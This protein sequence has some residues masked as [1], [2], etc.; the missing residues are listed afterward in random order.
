MSNT[1]LITYTYGHPAPVGGRLSVITLATELGKGFAG[2]A[3]SLPTRVTSI[4]R[5]GITMTAFESLAVLKDD[6]IGIHSVDLWVKSVNHAR[7]TQDAR[8]WSPDLTE[9][10]RA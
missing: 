6:L 8:V 2:K 10:R 1:T 3:C 4:T 7:I 9:A 5:Q